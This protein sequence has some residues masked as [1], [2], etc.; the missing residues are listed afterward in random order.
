[1]QTTTKNNRNTRLWESLKVISPCCGSTL[2]STMDGWECDNCH[3]F[4]KFGS[5]AK[6]REEVERLRS[7]TKE[8]VPE[9]VLVGVV[10]KRFGGTRR[11]K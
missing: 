5:I 6:Y 11:M 4:Y 7:E 1:M 3:L 2:G 10:V 8:A 9:P